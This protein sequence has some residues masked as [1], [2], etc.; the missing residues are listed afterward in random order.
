MRLNVSQGQQQQRDRH[1]LV[2]FLGRGGLTQHL[3][4]E[5]A[6]QM[7]GA[8]SRLARAP[9]AFAIDRHHGLWSQCRQNA[10]QPAPERRFE[11][12]YPSKMPPRLNLSG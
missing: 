8:G 9:A 6:D 11:M 4:G 10:T 5:G 2:R 12:R 7:Q 3:G 1:F